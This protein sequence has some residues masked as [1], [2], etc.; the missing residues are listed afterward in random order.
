MQPGDATLS[1]ELAA[2][3]SPTH[4][5]ALV[6]FEIELDH[7]MRWADSYL[8]IIRHYSKEAIKENEAMAAFVNKLPEVTITQE[9]KA[10]WQ[11]SANNMLTI[12]HAKAKLVD[13]MIE[14][15]IEPLEG[16]YKEMREIKT[17]VKAYESSREKYDGAITR[18][19]SLS[20]G[21][22]AAALREESLVLFEFRKQYIRA[23]FEIT[24]RV[25]LF[26][27]KMSTFMQGRMLACISAHAEFHKQAAEVHDSLIA[28]M[29]DLKRQAEDG[30]QKTRSSLPLESK[31]KA[32]EE[33][34]L[35]KARP[36]DTSVLEFPPVLEKGPSRYMNSPSL[37]NSLTETPVEKE[38]YLFKRSASGKSW[39]RKYFKL[40][41]GAFLYETTMAKHPGIVLATPSVNI[42]LC[43]VRVVRNEERRFCFEW[44]TVYNKHAL[45]QAE[46]EEELASWISC[47]EAAK[48]HA[49]THAPAAGA[50]S[51][52]TIGDGNHYE[53]EDGIPLYKVAAVGIETEPKAVDDFDSSAEDEEDDGGDNNPSG[54]EEEEHPENEI[55]YNDS[56]LKKENVRLHRLL[57][58][59]PR[60]DCV[61]DAFSCA[62]RKE[63]AV[64]GRLYLTYDRICFYSNI[65]GFV[66]ML[67]LNL[68]QVTAVVI[69]R[70]PLYTALLVTNQDGTHTFKSFLK[71]DSRYN[72]IKTVW[73]NATRETRIPPQEIYEAAHT[74]KV[75]HQ[76]AS[77]TATHAELPIGAD[78][79]GGGGGGGAGGVVPPAAGEQNAN[80]AYALPADVPEPTAEVPC[81]CGPD[82]LEQKDVDQVFPCPAKRLYDILFDETGAFWTE[83]FHPKRGEKGR[84]TTPWVDNTREVRYTMPV[85]N[86]MVKVKEAEVHITQT[87]VKSTPYISYTVETKSETPA[88]PYADAFNPQT[89]YCIT[90]VSKTSCRLIMTC[91]ILWHKSPMV[92]SMIRKAAMSGMAEGSADTVNLLNKLLAETSGSGGGTSSASADG[93]AATAGSNNP[94]TA[95]NDHLPGSANSS[96]SGASRPGASDSWF[97]NPM[98]VIA[99]GVLLSC[100]LLLHGAAWWRGGRGGA[101]APMY[102]PAPR[103]EAAWVNV[104][105]WS[106]AERESFDRFLTSHYQSV[107]QYKD[108]DKNNSHNHTTSML[109]AKPSAHGQY[110][111]EMHT[112]LYTRLVELQNEVRGVKDEAAVFLNHVNMAERE[113]VEAMFLNWMADNM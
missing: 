6:R 27:N 8:A 61:I 98:T 92:K 106:K 26:R 50:V 38:G 107:P 99:L 77:T 45:L 44:S 2:S 101:S 24:Q 15:V 100:S 103:P 18:Y 74:R 42:L 85:N 111:G 12:Y 7:S 40:E 5:A 113:V 56:A 93:A 70:N 46:T 88:L 64:R 58:Q 55:S 16:L 9:T 67:V 54:A 65:L 102:V 86:P 53:E 39:S 95:A 71:D 52:W 112:A 83:R 109:I 69:R 31:R 79:G 66:S 21:K 1:L 48:R 4:R 81:G 108:S 87:L 90:W 96:S 17:Y 43:S 28:N 14:I 3:D 35:T 23:A 82:H 25:L 33:A 59:V 84:T 104:I 76:R 68:K 41:K 63:I 22:E 11:S 80:S 91:G 73:Q 105:E 36:V 37:T 75:G 13:D 19:S 32:L 110:R 72:T 10:L 78:E 97:S 49:L 57:R 62:W 29:N 34:T 47:F 20:K 51:D 60:S 89:R 30:D 94:S